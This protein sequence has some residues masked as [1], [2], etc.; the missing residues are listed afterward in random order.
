MK[1][2][3][4]ILQLS[5]PSSSCLSPYLQQAFFLPLSPAHIFPL[6]A[7]CPLPIPLPTFLPMTSSHSPPAAASGLH[8]ESGTAHRGKWLV[9]CCNSRAAP[10]CSLIT[11]RQPCRVPLP[12]HSPC[13]CPA[14]G[15]RRDAPAPP[16]TGHRGRRD[17]LV[18]MLDIAALSHSSRPRGETAAYA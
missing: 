5:S 14:A 12:G 4:N 8:G 17:A 6:P 3:V 11:R 10:C 13:P 9:C 15:V 1:T 2:N 16:S 18:V 7:L